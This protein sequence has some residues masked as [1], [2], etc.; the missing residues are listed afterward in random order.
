LG[1]FKWPHPIEG[2]KRFLALLLDKGVAEKDVE[3]M[4]KTNPNQLI[5]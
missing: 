1:N 2:F 5:F 3:K 4:A